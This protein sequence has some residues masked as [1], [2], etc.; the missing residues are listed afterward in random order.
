[1]IK[2]YPGAVVHIV[3]N[4][5]RNA[6]VHGF[7][8]LKKGQIRIEVF[9][10]ED[11]ISIMIQDDGIGMDQTTLNQIYD[12]FFTTK[13]SRGGTG[14]GLNIVHNMITNVLQGSV[15]CESALGKGTQFT[16]QM[17]KQINRDLL[18]LGWTDTSTL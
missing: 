2:S 5:I 1:M 4:L 14:L 18:E 10:F 15:V 8:G 9:E 3:S 13:R 17:P 12:P 7:E 11:S 16:I 6:L